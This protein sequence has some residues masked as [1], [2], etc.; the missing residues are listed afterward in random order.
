MSWNT[1]KNRLEE[2]RQLALPALQ[3]WDQFVGAS[4]RQ[5]EVGTSREIKEG[6]QRSIA[7]S[8]KKKVFDSL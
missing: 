1:L 2:F 5:E 6:S 3:N 7:A 8:A 4:R